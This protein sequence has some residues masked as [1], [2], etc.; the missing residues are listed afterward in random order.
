MNN[1][2]LIDYRTELGLNYEPWQNKNDFLKV[3]I[4]SHRNLRKEVRKSLEE[5]KLEIQ[6]G[7]DYYVE[8]YVNDEFI[9]KDILLTMTLK[10]IVSEFQ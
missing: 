1:Q 6:K 9:K 4:D 3:L 7:V 2:L 10:E 8:H 5:K